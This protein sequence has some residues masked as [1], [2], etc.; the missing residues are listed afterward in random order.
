MVERKSGSSGAWIVKYTKLKKLH[1]IENIQ[2]KIEAS[3]EKVEPILSL[4]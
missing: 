2:K 4:C 1:T 3:F